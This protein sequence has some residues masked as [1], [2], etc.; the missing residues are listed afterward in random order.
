MDE[1][2]KD[3]A[4]AELIRAID[5]KGLINFTEITSGTAKTL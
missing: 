1:T 3:H 4:R 5:E 2:L